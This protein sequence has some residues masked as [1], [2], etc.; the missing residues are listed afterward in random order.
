MTSFATYWAP[1]AS[2]LGPHSVCALCAVGL[3]VAATRFLTDGPRTVFVLSMQPFAIAGVVVVALAMDAMRRPPPGFEATV[4]AV[5]LA[6]AAYGFAIEG[7]R[8]PDPESRVMAAL[9]VIPTGGLIIFVAFQAARHIYPKA[10]VAPYAYW[11][12]A[13]AVALVLAPPAALRRKRRRCQKH[14][15]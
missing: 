1:D 11:L 14:R 13:L 10:A 9:E 12:F 4:A 8:L 3:A 6:T 15:L 2:L 5:I 7:L